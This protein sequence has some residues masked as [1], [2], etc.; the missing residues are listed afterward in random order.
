MLVFSLWCN[1]GKRLPI[2]RNANYHTLWHSQLLVNIAW[3][4]GLLSLE[5]SATSL[6][7]EPTFMGDWPFRFSSIQFCNHP[8]GGFY[9]LEWSRFEEGV[10]LPKIRNIRYNA[11]IVVT[12]QCQTHVN[13]IFKCTIFVGYGGVI[14]LYWCYTMWRAKTLIRLCRYSGRSEFFLYSHVILL[15]ISQWSSIKFKF[16]LW[17]SLSLSFSP[18]IPFNRTVVARWSW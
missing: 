2:G 8:K 10:V 18:S 4:Q 11:R 13:E 1:I 12:I 16:L 14:Q 9:P 3:P 6:P 5:S 15:V 17:L 7:K